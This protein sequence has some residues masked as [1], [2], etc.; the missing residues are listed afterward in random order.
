MIKKQF[1]YK[2][3]DIV[4]YSPFTKQTFSTTLQSVLELE[5]LS[6]IQ[7]PSDI[8]T[9]VVYNELFSLVLGKYQEHAII[10]IEKCIYE[11]EPTSEEKEIG[12]KNFFYRYV[13]LLN[14]TY[15]YYTT[16]LSQYK[17]AKSH[18]MDDIKAT[19]TN[20]VKFNDTPQSENDDGIYEGDDYITHFTKTEGESSSPLNTKIMRLKEI[21]DNYKDLMSD[22]VRDF[23]KIF[24]QE[25]C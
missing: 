21:Q 24:Y 16:L 25:D 6:T 4:T 17:E 5:N 15:E 10:K 9:N 3:G 2:Y 23:E 18:L 14:D 20:K 11:G 1:Y 22:W 13:S 7:L 12:F 8:T 19:N